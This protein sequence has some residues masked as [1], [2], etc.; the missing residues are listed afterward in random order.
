MI[1]LS[2]DIRVFIYRLKLIDF[3]CLID[4]VEHWRIQ[5]CVLLLLDEFN[6]IIRTTTN[7]FNVI[8]RTKLYQHCHI[9]FFLTLMQKDFLFPKSY[10]L[11]FLILL[12]GDIAIRTDNS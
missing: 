5:I 12:S 9:G 7:E 10:T 3:F 1:Q 11:P 6:V 4:I 8:L 2:V